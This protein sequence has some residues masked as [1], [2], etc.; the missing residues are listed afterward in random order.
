MRKMLYNPFS[1][2]GLLLEYVIL[3]C[4]F[5]VTYHRCATKQLSLLW[6]SAVK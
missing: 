6:G 2:Y 5:P 1:L 3:L 4:A